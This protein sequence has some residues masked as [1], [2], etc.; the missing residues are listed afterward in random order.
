MGTFE[1]VEVDSTAAD[2]LHHRQ[3]MNGGTVSKELRYA[4]KYF[5][6]DTAKSPD[7]RRKSSFPRENSLWGTGT[8]LKYSREW[9]AEVR[10]CVWCYKICLAET[11]QANVHVWR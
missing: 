8:V 10:L 3:H 5:D 9:A 11:G 6:H 1:L 2:L 4:G 7:V